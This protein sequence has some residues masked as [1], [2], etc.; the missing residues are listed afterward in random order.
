M[1]ARAIWKAVLRIGDERI[2]VRL[3]TA[4]N[5]TSVHFRLLHKKDKSPVRQQLVNPETEEAVEYAAAQRGFVTDKGDLVILTREDMEA[6]A[7]PESREVE[8]LRFLPTGSIDHR[9]YDRP[10]YLGPDGAAG[11][12]AALAEALKRSGREG[13][14]RWVMRRKEYVGT[15]RLH[16]DYPVLITLRRA[17]E[18]VEASQLAPPGGRALDTKEIGLARQLVQMLAEDFDPSS[19]RDEYRERVL[20]LVKTKASGGKVTLM[21]PRR[22]AASEDLGKALRASLEREKKRA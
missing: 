2:P 7:P 11:D 21:K 18:M 8:V 16:G 20:K 12:F 9:W 15:L 6:L 13:V 1:A 19:Y 17:E 4:I 3:F 22:K 10:Y 5:D 14:A